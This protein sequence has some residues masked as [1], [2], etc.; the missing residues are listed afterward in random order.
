MKER[1]DNDRLSGPFFIHP[2]QARLRKSFTYQLSFCVSGAI[3]RST[4]FSSVGVVSFGY[5]PIQVARYQWYEPKSSILKTPDTVLLVLRCLILDSIG[6][7]SPSP[8]A[9]AESTLDKGI[10]I[11]ADMIDEELV[12]WWSL[13]EASEM[14]RYRGQLVDKGTKTEL[15]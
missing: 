5:R 4:L 14:E 1:L 6:E 3:W 12:G 2:S 13:S 8:M 15:S 7:A 10:S 9:E 11:S